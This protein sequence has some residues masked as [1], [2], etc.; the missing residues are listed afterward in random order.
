MVHQPAM[1]AMDRASLHEQVLTARVA[2]EPKLPGM[3]RDEAVA[4]VER[5]RREAGASEDVGDLVASLGGRDALVRGLVRFGRVQ[6]RALERLRDQLLGGGAAFIDEE[7]GTREALE[8]I[9]RRLI[10]AQRSMGPRGGPHSATRFEFTGLGSAKEIGR[11]VQL[12][13][14]LSGSGGVGRETRIGWRANGRTVGAEQYPLDIQQTLMLPVEMIDEQGKLVVE[15]HN[16]NPAGSVTFDRDDGIR[17]FYTAG[18]FGPNLGRGLAM[19]LVKLAFL[20]ALGLTAATFLGFPV[21]SLLA[22]LVFAVAEASPFIM[23]SVGSFGA[24]PEGPTL[25]A[26]FVNLIASG[27]GGALRQF[28]RF[29]P[30]SAITHGRMIAWPM[31]VVCVAWIGLLWTGLT[32]VVGWVI[33]RKRELARV[34]V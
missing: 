31:L 14:K 34:Q 18:R 26:R 25:L 12:Q 27:A 13:F 6:A 5:Y 17:L 3:S 30:A 29:E 21:A 8:S 2:V 7:G 24:T 33:F 16:L 32:F 15:A 22:L 11:S 20:A 1:D 9:R 4:W 19:M 10:T 23:E 28:A